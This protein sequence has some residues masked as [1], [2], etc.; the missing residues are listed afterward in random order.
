MSKLRKCFGSLDQLSA[1]GTI[2]TTPINLISKIQQK[3]KF[4]VAS[5]LQLLHRLSGMMVVL[6]SVCIF[7]NICSQHGRTDIVKVRL[8]A[9]S[10]QS[11]LAYLLKDSFID[12]LF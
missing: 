2:N 12:I 9:G 3:Y 6:L 5:C 7:G 1:Y 11:V 10:K 8:K 4:P